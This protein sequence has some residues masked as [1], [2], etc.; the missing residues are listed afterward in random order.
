[1]QDLSTNLCRISFFHSSK[2]N[3]FKE[4]INYSPTVLHSISEGQILKLLSSNEDDLLN[5]FKDMTRDRI[6]RI[7]PSRHEQIRSHSNNFNPVLFWSLGCQVASM[8]QHLCDAYL[9]INDGRFRTNGSCGYVLK[10]SHM[11][12]Y[13][14]KLRPQSISTKWSFRVL[15]A[16]NLPKPN[17]KELFGYISNP[18]VRIT[19]YDGGL[20]NPR[21]HITETVKGNGFNPV[22]NERNGV[23]FSDISYPDSAIV[24][25][26]LWN[27]NDKDN[28]EDFIA[29]SAIP[30]DSMRTGYRSIPLFDAN[31][32]RGGMYAYASLFVHIQ[33]YKSKEI[34]KSNNYN[35]SSL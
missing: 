20:T 23:I 1:M 2:F 4:T 33:N 32:M 14:S 25:F 28:T 7:F 10:P 35:S 17:G 21:V 9:L 31:H 24:L 13:K 27:H 19:L 34:E 8:Q 30:L 16:N 3:Y 22:W 11:T 18:R 26:S 29:A 6:V 15:S 12:G 5:Q